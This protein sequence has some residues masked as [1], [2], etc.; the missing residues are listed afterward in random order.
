M[1]EEKQSEAKRFLA[2]LILEGHLKDEAREA[3]LVK[4]HVDALEGMKAGV[5][6]IAQIA[7]WQAEA[8]VAAKQKR[9]AVAKKGGEGRAAKQAPELKRLLDLL[10]ERGVTT[11]PALKR[12]AKKGLYGLKLSGGFLRL[13]DRQGKPLPGE[14]LSWETVKDR[15]KARRSEAREKTRRK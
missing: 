3:E 10:F 6:G 15:Q 11:A 13:T 12:E 7:R 8:Q 2:K 5:D 9:L 14:K 1:S 4:P